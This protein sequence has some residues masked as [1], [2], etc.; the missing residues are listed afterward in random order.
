MNKLISNCVPSLFIVDYLNGRSTLPWCR[1]RRRWRRW[2]GR[3]CRAGWRGRG[4]GARTK[5]ATTYRGEMIRVEP[6]KC[7]FNV[8]PL[9]L[10]N[11]ADGLERGEVFLLGSSLLTLHQNLIISCSKFLPLL[12][13]LPQCFLAYSINLKSLFIKFRN[14]PLLCQMDIPQIFPRRLKI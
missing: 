8:Y 13:T 3:L 11:P 12:Q 7:M 10:S 4:T 1:T 2:W 5:I 14:I 6:L 9:L